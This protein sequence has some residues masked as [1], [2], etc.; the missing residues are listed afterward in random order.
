MFND[1]LVESEH[2]ELLVGLSEDI[3][4]VSHHTVIPAM[5]SNTSPA[6]YIARSS[7]IWGS[8][9]EPWH[10]FIARGEAGNGWL[11]ANGTFNP[12]GNQWISIEL[13]EELEIN[14]YEVATSSGGLTPTDTARDWSFEYSPD[15]ENWVLIDERSGQV[16]HGAHVWN[17]YMLSAPVKAKHYR[18]RITRV[19]DS[20]NARTRFNRFQLFYKV[21]T[22]VSKKSSYDGMTGALS[23]LNSKVEDGVTIELID[24]SKEEK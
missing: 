22:V 1:V 5:S 24:F 14:G 19:Q 6:G 8:G 18:W 16:Y 11:S 9:H 4:G 23:S 21:D 15:G 7:S 13:P 12:F 20:H 3:V 2:N 10:S 17:T